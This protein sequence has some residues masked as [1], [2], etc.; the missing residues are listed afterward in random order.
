MT[1]DLFMALV[2]FAFVSSVTPGP[3][4]TMLLASGVNHGFL[5]SVPHILGIG[6]GFGFMTVAVGL[7]LSQVFDAYPALYTGLRYVGGAYM[8]Y[9]AW[10]IAR[11]GPVGEGTS[12]RKPMTFLG[13]ALFQWVNPKA[14]ILAVSAIATYALPQNYLWNLLLVSAIFTVVNLPTVSIW[15]LFGTG[16][17]RFLNDPHS[18]RIFNI[19]M[20]L[21]LVVSLAPIL[22]H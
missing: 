16:L 22:W 5:G 12:S 21:L 20:A 15:V 17:R 18:L 11:S 2:V 7:G 14:W 4:N 9:L 10:K 3:N 1:A 8:L 6:L 13:A 19:T